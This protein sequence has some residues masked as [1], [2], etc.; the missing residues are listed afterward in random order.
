MGGADARRDVICWANL[1]QGGRRVP[2]PRLRETSSPRGSD[3]RAEPSGGSLGRAKL[4]LVIL[5]WLLPAQLARAEGPSDP[6]APPAVRALDPL[7]EEDTRQ[8]LQLDLLLDRMEALEAD[9]Q[10][11]RADRWRGLGWLGLSAA[12]TTVGLVA[13]W[14]RMD[15][16][17]LA[18]SWLVCAASGVLLGLHLVWQGW[19]RMARAEDALGQLDRAMG[20]LRLSA[21]P[22]FSPPP[23]VP[24]PQAG[25]LPSDRAA[26]EAP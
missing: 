5:A 13:T 7:A 8:L 23:L 9:R 22:V 19:T 18:T 1:V 16:Q 14:D 2:T 10:Q 20:E 11:G 24:E 4:L 12:F 17:P 21:S 6:M 15:D 26:D 25:P 3:P